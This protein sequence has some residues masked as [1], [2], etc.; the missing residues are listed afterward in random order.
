MLLK[1]AICLPLRYVERSDTCGWWSSGGKT[2]RGSQFYDI[3]A[4]HTRGCRHR[5]YASRT[6]QHLCL[7]DAK[8]VMSVSL[9]TDL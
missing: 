6:P 3:S 1:A 9:R 2:L 8:G 5:T 7:P 4:I